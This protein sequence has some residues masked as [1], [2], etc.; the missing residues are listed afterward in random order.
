MTSLHIR[1]LV[2]AGL[3]LLLS[4]ALLFF[5]LATAWVSAATGAHNETLEVVWYTL[6]PIWF[7]MVMA[8]HDS[9]PLESHFAYLLFVSIPLCSLLYGYAISGLFS[10]FLT[11]H[12]DDST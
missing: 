5:G 11:K 7:L 8:S 9:V 1:A 4:L 6:Q 12:D 10:L 3:H 2:I